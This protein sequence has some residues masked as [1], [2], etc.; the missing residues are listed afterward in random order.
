MCVCESVELEW[1]EESVCVWGRG[2]LGK[3]PGNEPQVPLTTD[4]LN[5][6][7]QWYAGVTM[8]RSSTSILLLNKCYARQHG[9]SCVDSV[10]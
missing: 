7:G 4:N 2:H 3:Q 5:Q 6:K 10:V 9:E 1:E 8:D